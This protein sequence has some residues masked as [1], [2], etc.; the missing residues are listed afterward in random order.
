MEDSNA[1]RVYLLRSLHIEHG[2]IP[3]SLK[4]QKSR[5]LLAWL[6][7]HPGQRYTRDWLAEWLWP[8]EEASVGRRKLKRSLFE[9]R[10][11]FGARLESGRNHVCLLADGSLWVDALAFTERLAST[12]DS[13]AG[14]TRTDSLGLL[15]WLETTV[16]LYRGSFLDGI[17]ASGD[18]AC[19][20]WLQDCR[21]RYRQAA[22]QLYQ[23]LA[24]G[25]AA[26]GDQ[27]RALRYRRRLTQEEPWN[28]RAWQQ[29]IG[30]LAGYG[31]H[32]EAQNVL[33]QCRSALASEL[34]AAPAAETLALLD[35]APRASAP[36]QRRMT[37]LCCRL[38]GPDGGDLDEL[39]ALQRPLEQCRHL[40][41]EAGAQVYRSASDDLLAFFGYPLAMENAALR[42]VGAALDCLA[43]VGPPLEAFCTLHSGLTLS[44]PDAD[45]PDL[46]GRLARL[47]LRLADAAPPGQLLASQATVAQLPRE[48]FEM[49]PRPPLPL[50]DNG[51]T[52]PVWLIGARRE[53]PLPRRSEPP[54]GRDAIL[55]ALHSL[56]LRA[57]DGAG[58]SVLVSG[59]A[60]IGKSTVLQ[61]FAGQQAL[62]GVEL[63]CRLESAAT[64]LHP[65]L[66][67]LQRL[68]TPADAPGREALANLHALLEPTRRTPALA[69]DICT[70]LLALLRSQVPPGG[71]ICIDDAH[72]AD[73]STRELLGRLIQQ[74]L[75]GRLLLIASRETL[76]PAWEAAGNSVHLH[77]QALCEEA[78]SALVGRLSGPQ[79][80]PAATVRQIARNCAG[81][82]L[83]IEEMTLCL[84][85]ADGAGP[86]A[87]TL[88]LSLQDLLMA[89]IDSLAQA[90]PL[91]QL[92]AAF[93]GDFSPALLAEA[94]ELEP[95]Q[96][97]ALLHTLRQQQLLVPGV[98]Q[99]LAFRHALLREAAYQ[100]M[101]PSRRR[102][103]HGRI[104]ASL[105]RRQPTLAS[106][107]PDRLAWHSER[108]GQTAAARGYLLAAGRLAVLRSAYH[109][110]LEHYRH[111]L[112]LLDA[113][114]DTREELQ[115]RMAMGTPLA[116]VYGNG[117]QSCR[118]NFNRA[119][120]LA[121]P[122]GDDPQL[123]PAYW[124]LWLGSSSW[125][126]YR[127]SELIARRLIRLAQRSA[128]PDLLL[129]GYYALG[130]SLFSMGRFHE[131]QACL[132]G[133]CA[134]PGPAPRATLLMGEDARANSLSF[135]ALAEWFC[136]REAQ[137]R[138]ASAQA[139]QRARQQKSAYVVCQALSLAALFG[140][141]SA[142]A[143]YAEQCAE[144][145]L[146]I[147]RKHDIA[148][149]SMACVTLLGWAQAVRGRAEALA[150]M[151]ESSAAVAQVMGGSNI[152][153]Q[154]IIADAAWH[155]GRRD[156]GLAA[157]ERGL[158]T[159]QRYAGNYPL[160]ELLRLKGEWLCRERDTHAR[161]IACLEQALDT[162]SRQDSPPLILRAA[163]SLLGQRPDDA[164]LSERLA[165]TQARLHPT[166]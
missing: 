115:L 62:P 96:F 10:E 77:L 100:S 17:Q 129:H 13:A 8:A 166:G 143:D 2:A 51:Q 3:R 65:F 79:G 106:E 92:A 146:A 154:S 52:L 18:E 27:Q 83:F 111:A 133:A 16:A 66:H 21:E 44:L 43:S 86:T 153:F 156:S 11:V 14:P 95:R 103:V 36:E 54:V 23:R 124:G 29:L 59:E 130:N 125:R 135:L 63:I 162:A 32:G 161:G 60:G 42:A 157:I 39:L 108:A 20:L 164:A 149:W 114:S 25:F 89:H 78:S 45:V 58:L 50:A 123:F 75:P 48:R 147:A 34:D 15:E 46:G 139:L 112:A 131:A 88:P 80:L 158:A 98:E 105:Q 121:E 28:E 64:P 119:L 144:E 12:K 57:R 118:D 31:H 107:E 81:I 71:I 1:V 155:A 116:I 30:L 132:L 136:G 93:D 91:A 109:E 4:Y 69:P 104:L 94:A 117:A 101:P 53:L 140:Q 141:I 76:N 85:A 33:A 70:Q 137:A 159:A 120:E 47:A 145:G 127:Q 163:R 102:W 41:R 49:S 6:A 142:D 5:L 126:G 138:A 24:A 134:L 61:F 37:V 56:C 90:K 73:P 160:A 55:H 151:L 87:S 99:E 152:F 40:L 19:D 150:T 35:A 128:D 84:R 68:P 110:A 67:W 82:P 113:G 74:P 72:W 9:L 38:Q 7:L 22:L 148:L 26:H 122:L 165:A 97:E